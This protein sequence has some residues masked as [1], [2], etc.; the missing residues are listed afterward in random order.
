MSEK[1][2]EH[3]SWSEFACHDGTPVPNELR[4]NTK[5]LCE[6]L[7][8]LRAEIGVP[9]RILSGYRTPAWNK[10]VGGAPLSQHIKAKAADICTASHTPKQ[11]HTIIQRLIAL[12]KMKQGGLG[13]Y[14]SWVHYDV[15]GRQARWTG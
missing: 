7:E 13:L 1:I 2:T 10:G 12:G 9:I 6:N 5:L 4:E 15:R 14:P 11:L 8:V 3:F